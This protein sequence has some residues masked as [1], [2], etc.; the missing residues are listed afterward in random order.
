MMIGNLIQHEFLVARD[1]PL[2][3]AISCVLMLFVV[4]MM[5]WSLRASKLVS[6]REHES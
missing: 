2:G 3:A 5:G 4:G 6:Q 1:W